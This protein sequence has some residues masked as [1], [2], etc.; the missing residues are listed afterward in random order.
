MKVF[1]NRLRDC[2]WKN[3]NVKSFIEQ[4]LL[5]GRDVSIPDFFNNLVRRIKFLVTFYQF[6][7]I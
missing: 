4:F 2:G 5:G 6:K 1:L 7:M 3:I